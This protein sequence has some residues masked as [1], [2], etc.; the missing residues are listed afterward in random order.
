VSPTRGVQRLVWKENSLL[1]ML[2]LLKFLKFV[3]P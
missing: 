2:D 1:G 3:D